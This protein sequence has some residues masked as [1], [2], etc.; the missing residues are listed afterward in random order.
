MRTRTTP[1]GYIIRL[2]EEQHRKLVVAFSPSSK[3]YHTC[4]LC[5]EAEKKWERMQD[6]TKY[7]VGIKCAVCPAYLPYPAFVMCA[8]LVADILD[9]PKISMSCLTNMRLT[10]ANRSKEEKKW[11]RTLWTWLREMDYEED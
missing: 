1:S 3:K 6:R 4:P 7:P 5:I 11:S 10:P 2:T 8:D 9:V